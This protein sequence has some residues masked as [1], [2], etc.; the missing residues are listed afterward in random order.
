MFLSNF[1]GFTILL[2]NVQNFWAWAPYVAFPRYAYEGLVA[3]TFNDA[4][5]DDYEELLKYFGFEN[6]QPVYSILV[7]VPYMVTIAFFVLLALLPAKSKLKIDKNAGYSKGDDD[8]EYNGD[9]GNTLGD[10]LKSPLLSDMLYDLDSSGADNDIFDPAFR[11]TSTTGTL[12]V[13]SR[14]LP[15]GDPQGRRGS[16][17]VSDFKRNSDGLENIVNMNTS[18]DVISLTFS[19]ISY[20]VK[21]KSDHGGASEDGYLTILNGVSGR[22][23][24]GEMVAL[25]GASGAGKSTLLDLVAGRK[26]ADKNTLISGDIFFNGGP[27]TRSLMRRTTYVTQDNVHLESLTVHQTLSFAA[28]LRMS[29]SHESKRAERVMLIA[30]M[31]G[32]DTILD[33]TVGGSALRGI[34]GGQLKRL[35]VAVEIM[36]LPAVIFLDEPT[37]GLDSQIAHEVMCAV[38]NL[39]DQNRT[40]ITTIHQPSPATFNLFDKLLLLSNGRTTFFGPVDEAADY[41]GNL[42]YTFDRDR[43][44]ANVADFVVS[45]AGGFSEPCLNAVALSHHF[46]ESEDYRHFMD[47]F[48]DNLRLDAENAAAAELK[49]VFPS[50]ASKKYPR[51]LRSQ[52][53]ILARRQILKTM[54]NPKPIVAGVARQVAVALFYGSIYHNLKNDQILERSSLCFFTVMFVVLGHQQSIPIVF[55]ERLLFYRERAAKVYGDFGYFL[56]GGVAIFP[57]NMVYCFIFVFVLYFLTGFRRTFEAVAFFFVV[58]AACSACGLFYCQLLACLCPSQQ[59]AITLFPATLFFFIAFAGYII[60]IPSLPEW[61]SSW[62]PSISFVRWGFQALMINEFKGNEE[63]FPP[64]KV[65][66]RTISTDERY[67]EFAE[68]Y[69]FEG[70]EKWDS[71]IFLAIN[72]LVFRI[73]TFLALH[74]V[75]H[76]KR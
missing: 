44:G 75:K 39:A 19:D 35:S 1:A 28:A 5:P 38:R 8:V 32:L 45:V 50:R 17:N 26:K 34:S 68:T 6:W 49:C 7:L 29:D 58:V 66:H 70:Y 53:I 25:M 57:I 27:P 56:T 42:G 67:E 76:E 73:G 41:F 36:H 47:S 46:N 21:V 61:L 24:P 48:E 59:T 74:Y 43:I 64:I 40:V 2:K 69:G 20:A 63:V 51:S 33:S 60:F 10:E 9:D 55:D 14:E 4:Q 62:A 18:G 23:Q 72:A 13:D 37:T 30:K 52:C 16:W 3:V 15:M 65:H 12:T 54:Q 22:I 31:L 11:H 71:M